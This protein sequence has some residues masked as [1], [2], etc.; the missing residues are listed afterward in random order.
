LETAQVFREQGQEVAL[1]VLLETINPERLRQQ[2]RLV[3][4]MAAVRGKINLLKS[5]HKYLRSLG[6]DK[7]KDYRSGSSAHKLSG[8]VQQLAASAAKREFERHSVD[9]Q[10]AA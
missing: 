6:K 3:Q 4:M 2:T 7:A 8:P 5:E 10:H 9:K 1:L